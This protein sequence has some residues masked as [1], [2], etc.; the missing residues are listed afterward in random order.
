MK[1]SERQKFKDWFTRQDYA[2]LTD[3]YQMLQDEYTKRGKN[4]EIDRNVYDSRRD[5]PEQMAR[6]LSNHFDSVFE[7]HHGF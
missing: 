2:T 4:I 5:S 1:A 6:T 7:K 3:V